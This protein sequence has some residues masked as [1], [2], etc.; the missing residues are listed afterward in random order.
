LDADVGLKKTDRT[1]DFKAPSNRF[2]LVYLTFSTDGV[3]AVVSSPI[4]C[5]DGLQTIEGNTMF[6]SSYNRLDQ[7]H[8]PTGEGT[9]Q[10][11]LNAIERPDLCANRMT[12]APL[13]RT[14]GIG[15]PAPRF[16][17]FCKMEGKL[18]ESVAYRREGR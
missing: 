16:K 11:D 3:C 1:E 2:R 7:N 9:G 12:V 4:S 10:S 14:G 13:P 8:N 17:L 15:E 6:I 18:G 5:F